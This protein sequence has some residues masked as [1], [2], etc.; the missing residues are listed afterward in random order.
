MRLMGSREDRVI[1]GEG[2]REEKVIE[3]EEISR[4]ELRRVVRESKDG[5]AMGVDG[6][7][8]EVWKYGGAGMEEWIWGFCNKVWCGHAGYEG[9]RGGEG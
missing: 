6:I 3:E 2:R 8:D 1:R 4:E 7:P 9:S 5:K